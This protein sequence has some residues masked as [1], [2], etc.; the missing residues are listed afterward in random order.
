M[1][2]DDV[3]IRRGSLEVEAEAVYWYRKAAGRA[4]LSRSTIWGMLTDG[5][6]VRK[7]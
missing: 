5:R 3:R 6:G 1:R 4:I 7:E 2:W